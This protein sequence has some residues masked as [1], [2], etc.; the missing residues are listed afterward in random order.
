MF[1]LDYLR[2][3]LLDP[4]GI[5]AA[6][7]DTD[8]RGGALGFTGLHLQT[9]SVARFGQLLLQNGEWLGQ[10]VLP[11]GWVGIRAAEL[12]FALRALLEEPAR[13]Y[14]KSVSR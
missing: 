2:P 10:Q 8:E 4:L 3:R 13:A 7:W 14:V 5:G 1:L 6:H 12:F 9:E 11:E